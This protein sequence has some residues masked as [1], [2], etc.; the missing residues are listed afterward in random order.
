MNTINESLLQNI[1]D[2][3]ENL[4]L[5]IQDVS[6]KLQQL[7]DNQIVLK[8]ATLN[9]KLQVNSNADIT[10]DLSVSGKLTSGELIIP[11]KFSTTT[12]AI[13]IEPAT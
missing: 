9:N 13:W 8:G 11:N 2:T 1:N 10:K 6:D 12:G 3:N 5:A 4:L 7:I